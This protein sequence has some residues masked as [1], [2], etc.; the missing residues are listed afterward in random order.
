MLDGINYSTIS[1]DIKMYRPVF[2]VKRYFGS[3]ESNKAQ[4]INYS[5]KISMLIYKKMYEGLSF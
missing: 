3:W 4:I 1:G 5:I 2:D